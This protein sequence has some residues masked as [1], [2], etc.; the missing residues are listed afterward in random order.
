[1]LTAYLS[2]ARLHINYS[3]NACIGA[4]CTGQWSIGQWFP[5]GKTYLLHLHLYH[6]YFI[7]RVR[8]EIGVQLLFIYL[9]SYCSETQTQ[10]V[11]HGGNLSVWAAP[12]PYCSMLL[13]SEI[14]ITFSHLWIDRLLH[15]FLTVASLG[16]SLFTSWCLN[17]CHLP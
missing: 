10:S 11:V 17:I 1:M 7:P 3:M 6:S 13:I 8:C 15:C 12:Q 2:L 14:W 16:V 9:I 5:Q 4:S